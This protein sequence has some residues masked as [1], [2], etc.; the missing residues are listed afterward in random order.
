M[1][2]FKELR[3]YAGAPH[4]QRPNKKYC[5]FQGLFGNFRVR[6]VGKIEARTQRLW[7]LSPGR[8]TGIIWGWL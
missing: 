2:P 7:V 8:P 6:L 3:C 5:R 1:M 4:F